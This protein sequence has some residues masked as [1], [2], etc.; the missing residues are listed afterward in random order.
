MVARYIAQ[1]ADRCGVFYESAE[2]A[3]LAPAIVCALAVRA[4]HPGKG[5]TVIVSN[6][7]AADLGRGD[8]LT[9]D[10][11]DEVDVAFDEAARIACFTS[12]VATSGI[13]GTTTGAVWLCELYDG[14]RRVSLDTGATKVEA[15]ENAWRKLVATD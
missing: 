3:T 10:E 14:A 13:D 2:F 8:G 15:Q 1:A 6:I 11:R 5:H 9:D 7:D 12:E 4:R